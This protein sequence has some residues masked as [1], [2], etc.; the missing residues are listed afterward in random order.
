M[1]L[2]SG[3][4]LL[5]TATITYSEGAP[6]YNACPTLSPAF[7]EGWGQGS[8]H[9]ELCRPLKGLI[10]QLKAY[11]A[12]RAQP[13]QRARH[14]CSLG[15][16]VGRFMLGYPVPSRRAGLGSRQFQRRFRKQVPEAPRGICFTCPRIGDIESSVLI[17]AISR[18]VRPLGDRNH[19]YRQSV[20]RVVRSQ[21]RRAWQVCAPSYSVRLWN[22]KH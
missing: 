6:F 17:R 8:A 20:L 18:A 22:E 2:S 9:A 7:G 4:L 16:S 1:F 21:N 5:R 19:E 12:F 10:I 13:P 14:R 3:W 11:P 15:T